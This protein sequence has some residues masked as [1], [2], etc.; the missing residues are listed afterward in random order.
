ME[1]RAFEALKFYWDHWRFEPLA[2]PMQGLTRRVSFIKGG[3]IGEVGRYYVHDTILWSPEHFDELWSALAPKPEVQSQRFLVLTQGGEVK[4][5]RKS[6]WLGFRG[7]GEALFWPLGTDVGKG[8]KPMADLVFLVSQAEK[9]L[10]GQGLTEEGRQQV[11][12]ELKA[13]GLDFDQ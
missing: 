2:S 3:L 6:F 10:R 7:Y 11:G 5:L 1:L 4:S 13:L 12:A 9:M 8:T